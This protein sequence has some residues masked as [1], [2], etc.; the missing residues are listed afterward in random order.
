MK[1]HWRQMIA[2]G[3]AVLLLA[4][5]GAKGESKDSAKGSGEKV[6]VGV[7]QL[8]RH[9]ALDQA[10]EGF[11]EQLAARGYK[12]GENLELDF[13]DAQGDPSNAVTI[14]QKVVNS[15]LNLIFAIA[16]PAAQAVANQTQDIPIVITAVTDPAASG[17]VDSNEKPGNNVTGTSDLTPVAEQI[18]LL[19]E[20]IPTAKRVGVLFN[21]SE[22]N[23]IL[24]A[25][26][27]KE[28]LEKAGLE[29]V[30]LTVSKTDDIQPVVRSAMGKIDALYVP[31]DNLVS[32][33]LQAVTDI[34]TP[35]KI[36][37][38]CGEAA[39]LEKGGLATKG[40]DYKELGKISGDMAADILEGK[41]KP[42]DMPI[43]YQK[44][45]KLEVNE[46]VAKELGIEVPANLK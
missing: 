45:L 15:K 4:G 28:A 35:E 3:L 36:G 11:K 20:L 43:R 7:V 19:R 30:E 6:R 27:A 2:A 18:D 26:L 24:Q 32:A 1:R 12:E 22:D 34:T 25:R 10:Y 14:A 29:Y 38:I 33:N 40:I 37:V 23:S 46:E 41:S 31:T 9:N 39:M 5:C 17:L 16:T 42:A 13:N 8:A 44:E 21:S